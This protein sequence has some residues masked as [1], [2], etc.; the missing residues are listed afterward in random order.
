MNQETENLLPE[1]ERTPVA[2]RRDLHR[3]RLV[4]GQLRDEA[5][6]SGEPFQVADL[7]LDATALDELWDGLDRVDT[8]FWKDEIFRRYME[9]GRRRWGS[10]PRA[11]LV[12]VLGGRIDVQDACGGVRLGRSGSVISRRP[13]G[14]L[15]TACFGFAG[16][17]DAVFVICFSGHNI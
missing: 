10:A 17:I 16:T 1:P 14:T 8:H 15:E 12:E 6:A 11:P 7:A 13:Q 9:P 4:V 3:A 5:L 2:Y